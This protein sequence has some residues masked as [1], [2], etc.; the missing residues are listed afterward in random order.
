[1]LFA[2]AS[3]GWAT[4]NAS[5]YLFP[6]YTGQTIAADRDVATVA[7]CVVAVGNGAN[8]VRVHNVPMVAQGLAVAD[9]VYRR[10][11]PHGMDH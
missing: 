7:A 10:V 1:M 3:N 6:R 4:I 5:H 11:L 9:A 2:L 8:I